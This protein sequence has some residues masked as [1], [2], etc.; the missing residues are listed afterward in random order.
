MKILITGCAGFIGFHLSKRFCEMNCKVYGIDNLN[1]YYD[2][3]IKKD[4]LNILKNYKFFSFI[5]VDLKEKKKLDKLFRNF[6]FDFI[7]N[8]AAQAGVRYSIKFPQKY[9]D[10]NITGFFNLIE[11]SRKYKVKKIISASTSSVYGKNKKLPFKENERVDNI[12]QFYAATKRC[13]E[14]FGDVYSKIYD[15]NFVFLRFFTVYGPWGR[16]DMSLALFVSNIIK[17]KKINVFNYGNHQRDFTYVDDIVDGIIKA[18]Q[19]KIKKKFEIYNLGN[20]KKIKL[21]QYIKIIEKKL[22]AKAIIN[23][24]KLQKGDVQETLSN[25]SKSKRELKYKPKIN[26]KEG[27]D[28]YIKWFKEYYKVK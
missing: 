22:R 16:P 13:N 9:F 20:G 12:I 6:K 21:M 3:K 23:Y 18:C 10:S 25:I 14:I 24:K 1:N 17:K 19:K 8:L 15:I 28:N 27:I 2:V 4:R 7:V 5:K 11:L 26:I